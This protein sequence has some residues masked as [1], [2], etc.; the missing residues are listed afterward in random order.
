M[1]SVFYISSGIA[2]LATLLVVTRTNIVHALLFLIVSL[3]AVAVDLFVLGAQLAAALEVIIYAGAIMVL[4]IFVIMMMNLGKAEQEAN[5]HRRSPAW[6]AA[7]VLSA[8]LLAELIYVMVA[9]P[10]P[11][12][13]PGN[14]PREVA[15]LLYGPYV[16][17]VELAS[18]LLLSGLVGAYHLGRPEQSRAGTARRL[19]GS[20]ADSSS[21]S[22]RPTGLG[23]AE[24]K[25]Q[26]GAV[27][28][29]SS[30]HDSAAIGGSNAGSGPVPTQEE[31]S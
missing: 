28:A 25:T 19:D 10:G 18:L 8:V 20:P 30:G 3:L 5:R 23:R 9:N 15:K 11:P 26:L 29:E 7:G 4:F 22:A 2:V 17:A 12:V 1:T 13:G 21:G 16:L 24:R 14:D 31:P 27:V 6:L